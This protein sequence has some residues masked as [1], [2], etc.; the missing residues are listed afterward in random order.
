MTQK[1]ADFDAF[2]AEIEADPVNAQAL[3]DADSWIVET[4]YTSEPE[5]LRST[6]LRN[7]MSRSSWPPSEIKK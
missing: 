4:F 1:H 6:R 7:G 3:A 5:A 2:M